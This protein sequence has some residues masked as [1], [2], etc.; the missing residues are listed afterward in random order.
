V[1]RPE[2]PRWVAVGRMTRAHGVRG[3]VAVAPLSD[4]ADRLAPGSRL[5]VD[6]DDGRVVEIEQARPHRGRI[7]VT[8]AGI[9]D[10]DA[11]ERLAGSYLFVEAARSPTLPKG[12]FWTHQLIGLE[13]ITESG[14]ALGALREVIRTEANDVWVAVADDGTETLVPALNDV[15]ADVDVDGRRVVVRE[16]PGLTAPEG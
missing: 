11:A 1:S 3:E 14:R 13:V 6:E 12:E 2:R 7:L 4:V 8:F 10:R 9:A 16:V 5:V 15:V